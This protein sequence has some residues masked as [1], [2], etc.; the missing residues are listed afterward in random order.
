MP[1]CHAVLAWVFPA[2]L[3]DAVIHFFCFIV[4]NHIKC[5][6]G[7]LLALAGCADALIS[8]AVVAVLAWCYKFHVTYVVIVGVFVFVVNLHVVGY[9]TVKCFPYKPM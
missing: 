7:F 5:L 2:K 8:C 1:P 3:C 9:F 6:S 4:D